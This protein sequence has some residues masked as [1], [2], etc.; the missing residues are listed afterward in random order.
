MSLRRAHLIFGVTALL[1]PSCLVAQATFGGIFGTVVDST[2]ALVTGAKV[3]MTDVSK[4][5]TVSTFTNESGNYT[6]T[7][8]TVGTYK[9]S[10]EAKGF[11]SYLQENVPV[12]VDANTRV[13]VTL[14]VGD[15]SQE[16]TVSET[17]PLIQS[18]RAEVS[19]TLQSRE[20]SELPVANRNF[21]QLELM[22]PGTT[23]MTWQHASS[24][25]PQGGIQIDTNGQLFGMNNFMIDGADNNDP[26][27]GIIMINPAI[28][29]VQEFKLTSANY[30]AEFAQAGGSV[31][32]VE[33]KSGTNELHGSVFEFLQNNIFEA[34]DPFTQG[35]HDPG[36]P[37]PKNRGVPPLR[38]NQF[39]GSVGGP[40]LKNKLFFFGDYQG[41][42]R[43]TGA[44]LLTRVPTAAERQGDFSDFSIP[45]FDPLTGNADG[46]GRVQFADPSRGTAGN[47]GGL[48]IIPISR[49]TPQA[50]NLL[51]LLPPQNL[52][53]ASPNDPNYVTSGSEAFDSDQYDVRIDHYATDNLHYF[54]RYSLADFNKNSPAA[55]G[56]AGGPALNGL[57]FAGTSD[58]RN[59]N[60]VGGL[61]YT[62]APSLLTDV[63]FTFTR[64]RVK[65]LPLDYG[66]SAADKAGLPGLNLPNRIDTSG[67]PE[68]AIGSTSRG[69]FLEGFGLA[70]DQCNCPLIE[71]ENVFQAV[72]NWTKV[73]SN[74]TFKWGTD[75]RYANNIRLPSDTH[76]S[77]SFH[78][79]DSLTASADV[80]GSG[81]APASFLLGLPSQFQR[82]AENAIDPH[83]FQWRMFYFVQDT[84]RATTKLTFNY[85]LR[86]DTWFPDSSQHAGEG[87]RYEVTT[88]LIH[89]PGVGKVSQ[90]GDLQTQWHNFSPRISAAYSLTPRTVIRAGW[91]RSYFQ[92]I[93]GYTFNNL[94]LGYPTLISQV[95]NPASSYQA[96]FPL[97]VGPPLPV[98]P[99]IP[100]NG[101]LPLPNG[102]GA[103]YV[104]A[105]I[106]YPYV[107]AW[108]FSLAQQLSENIALELAYVGNVG[109]HLNYGFNLNA[110]VPGPGDLNPRRPL[111]NAYGLTQGINDSCD[112][113][114]SSYNALQV[115]GTRRFSKNYSV[116][117]N[118]TW[119]RAMDFGE[120]G[121]ATDSYNYALDKGPADFD[122][123][124][125]FNLS[126]EVILPFGPGQK[127]A[128]NVHGFARVLIEGWQWT[129]ITSLLS[130]YPFSPVLSNNASLNSDMSLRPDIVGDPEV[131]NQSANGW[132]NPSAYAVP[133]AYHFGDASRNSLRGPGAFVANWSFFKNFRINERGTNLQFRWENFNIF[134]RQNLATQSLVN[135]V[136]SGSAAGKIF[137]IAE[138]MRN[139]QFA[140]RLTF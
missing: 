117:A 72:N 110:A 99:T 68:L 34:R 65:V 74:H 32:Q 92:G 115:K 131:S 57:N 138:P 97:S 134:N 38:W 27:L 45:I 122:R 125:V 85:G 107:D 76:R 56:I 14:Q 93:F 69:G 130:G 123:A 118:L 51:A 84:W 1:C 64:Y 39:G 33:T 2:G 128:S 13:D 139:M 41:T 43:R 21:T 100:T 120:F 109:R 96:I 12:S 59:Q 137:D 44:S 11:K 31:I 79:N 111:F 37:A 5:V 6:K 7:Y 26:V 87:G 140:L 94:T 126:H 50:T 73:H 49:I 3:T 30:D 71:T 63:R 17:P 124:V 58:V 53:P 89:V 102:I 113:A 106:K 47:P 81:L 98:F 36:T 61:N 108:N 83:D 101:L 18:D 29:S 119:S 15:V 60:V 104:P 91:G 121:V 48:N 105:N 10:V 28:D 16:I 70:N 103:A 42:R 133:A 82:F 62:L 35:L 22:M 86:W 114:S 75:V 52:S 116:I 8:L 9:V 132:F 4:G 20:V 23:K 80:S 78:F 40:I 95:I 135:A 67:L 66:Q 136:D 77:G 88:N 127:F 112:C 46:S 25:N 55:F 129:G 54:G 90:S 24:E 19:D